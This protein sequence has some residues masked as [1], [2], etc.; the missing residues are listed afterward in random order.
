MKK[1]QIILAVLLVSFLAT[2]VGVL[3]KIRHLAGGNDWLA[4]GLAGA[5]VY[6]FMALYDVVRARHLPIP[7]RL[8]WVIGLLT[9]PYVA[10]WLYFFAYRRGQFAR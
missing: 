2:S 5:L 6:W 7:E 4:V 10:G 8:M 3:L 9:I 1:E